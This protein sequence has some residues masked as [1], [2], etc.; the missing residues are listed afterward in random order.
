MF[1]VM[2]VVGLFT[3]Y[4]KCTEC[5]ELLPCGLVTD[6]GRPRHRYYCQFRVPATGIRRVEAEESF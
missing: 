1:N 2:R 4:T 6:H 3:C 5:S